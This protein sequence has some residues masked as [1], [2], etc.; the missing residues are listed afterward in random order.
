MFGAAI[1]YSHDM[2]F[3]RNASSRIVVSVLSGF[4]SRQIAADGHSSQ[5]DSPIGRVR[6]LRQQFRELGAV[7]VPAVTPFTLSSGV[8]RR[9]VENSVVRW[10]GFSALG[11]DVV[12]FQDYVE[13]LRPP[14]SAPRHHGILPRSKR[15]AV[16][17]ELDRTLS[18]AWICSRAISGS[19]SSAIVIRAMREAC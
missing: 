16:S 12:C 9:K 2:Q 7:C 17:G 18:A 8:L 15:C 13:S 3:R 6:S 4:F 5:P 1:M 14:C 11:P 10:P 19:Q